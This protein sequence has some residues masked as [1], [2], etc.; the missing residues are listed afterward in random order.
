MNRT[1]AEHEGGDESAA[2]PAQ[3]AQ[4]EMPQQPA[5][6]AKIHMPQ[7]TP[8]LLDAGLQGLGDLRAELSLD[9]DELAVLLSMGC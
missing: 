2:E 6:G 1:D 5:P 7:P 4:T 3:S 8:A 9:D